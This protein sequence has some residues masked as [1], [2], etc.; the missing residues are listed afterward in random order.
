MEVEIVPENPSPV[1]V[2]RMVRAV[3]RIEGVYA[4]T[5]AMEKDG[6]IE[7]VNV[8]ADPCIDPKLLSRA[9]RNLFANSANVW[10]DYWKVNVVLMTKEDY[11]SQEA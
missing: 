1:L 7:V 3:R 5:A 9:V 8:V 6:S 10:L 4:A 2:A 11:E